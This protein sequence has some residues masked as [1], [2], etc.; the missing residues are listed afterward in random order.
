MSSCLRKLYGTVCKP[1]LIA[2]LEFSPCFCMDKSRPHLSLRAPHQCAK[3]PQPVSHVFNIAA[4]GESSLAERSAQL[5]RTQPV[6]CKVTGFSLEPHALSLFWPWCRCSFWWCR[7]RDGLF[8]SVD[9]FIGMRYHC[10]WS[11]VTGLGMTQAS[12]FWIERPNVFL[13]TRKWHALH[14]SVSLQINP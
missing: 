14:F 11:W 9:I 1:C 2:F 13:F 12:V 6:C 5:S 8:F 7:S 10:M 3:R 4:T